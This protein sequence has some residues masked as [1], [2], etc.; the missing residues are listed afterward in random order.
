[1]HSPL[2]ILEGTVDSQQLKRLGITFVQ[3]FMWSLCEIMLLYHEISYEYSFINGLVIDVLGFVFRV[4][5]Y[6][7]NV[8]GFSSRYSSAL[9]TNFAIP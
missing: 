5:R 3:Q 1:M 6:T 4:N 2:L 9:F 7:S 8:L